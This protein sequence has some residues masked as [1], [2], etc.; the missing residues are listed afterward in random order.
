MLVTLQGRKKH[1]KS[2]ILRHYYEGLGLSAEYFE[3]VEEL[4]ELETELRAPKVGR[5]T[6]PEPAKEALLSFA[7]KF[8]HAYLA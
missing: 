3:Y 1:K 2:K 4:F 7:L 6:L 8:L 5:Q